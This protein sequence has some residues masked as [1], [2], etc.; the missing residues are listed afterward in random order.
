M[1]L[2]AIVRGGRFV[3]D[4]PTDL[5]E[6]TELDLVIDDDS[7]ELD[8]DELKALNAAILASLEDARAGRT[9][10]ASEI[11]ALLRRRHSAGQ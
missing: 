2:K 3:I 1:G 4:A 11:L 9:K 6:G 8:P 10:P 7:D 5:P